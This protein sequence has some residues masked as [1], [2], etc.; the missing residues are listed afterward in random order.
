ML[1][2]LPAARL[3]ISLFPSLLLSVTESRSSFGNI[4]RT[5]SMLLTVGGLAPEIAIL[6]PKATA[7]IHRKFFEAFRCVSFCVCCCPKAHRK[8]STPETMPKTVIPG[9]NVRW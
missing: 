8:T 9:P 7:E 5:E 3:E 1:L 4:V 6:L 2:T